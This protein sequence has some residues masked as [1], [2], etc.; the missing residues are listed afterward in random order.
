MNI[1]A[2]ENILEFKSTGDYVYVHKDSLKDVKIP[3]GHKVMSISNVNMPKDHYK[4]WYV[5]EDHVF[6]DE[7]DLPDHVVYKATIS[8]E[9]RY[10]GVRVVHP[11]TK[12][13]LTWGDRKFSQP[14]LNTPKVFESAEDEWKKIGDDDE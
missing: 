12:E 11:I 9:D 10:G 13:I 1:D 8:E 4:V 3:A 6:V 14:K 7:H 2:V 5:R